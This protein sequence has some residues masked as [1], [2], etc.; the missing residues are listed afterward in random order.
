MDE[1]RCCI[2]E[3]YTAIS[4]R[5]DPRSERNVRKISEHV[6]RKS[7][8]FEKRYF[9]KKEWAAYLKVFESVASEKEEI[10]SEYSVVW[11]SDNTSVEDVLD[12]IKNGNYVKNESGEI[13]I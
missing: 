9:G 2:Y 13:I 8:I 6:R 4:C 7:C 11:A 5:T 3:K 1:K 10:K 12:L